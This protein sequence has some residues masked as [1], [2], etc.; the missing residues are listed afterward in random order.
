MSAFTINIPIRI[1][2]ADDVKNA[3][4]QS[5]GYTD[6]IE[7]AGVVVPNP[8]TKEEFVK[9]KC[10]NFMLEITRGYLIEQEEIIASGIAQ[11]AVLTRSQEV[12]GWFD[13]RRLE[14]LGGISVY[15]NFPIVDDLSITTNKNEATNFTLTGTD[16]DSL[17]LNFV[18]TQNPT[19]GTILGTNPNFIYVPSNR[20]YGSD[21]FK[22]KANNGTKK[23]LEGTV[24]ATV[25]RTITAIDAYHP[26][27]KNQS[28]NFTLSSYDTEGTVIYN[29]VDLP[30]HGIINGSNPYEY[31]P[32]T[33]FIGID[34]LSFQ[35]QDDTL[36]S[37][38][39]TITFDITNIIVQPQTYNISMNTNFVFVP[40][41]SNSIGIPSFEITNLPTNGILSQNN[42]EFTFTPNSNFT[43]QD[44][45]EIKAIDFYNESDPALFII[46]VS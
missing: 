6:T 26:I 25:N 11:N 41:T 24:S 5:Y 36:T 20:F 8:I 21:T 33:D 3:F 45:F 40:D 34:T 4:A 37:N 10:I 46:N 42:S 32:D 31:I 17:P 44:S 27:R 18:I 38:T 14:T 39:G 15:Q 23:S 1:I 2:D 13:D 35:V 22:F 12:V 30:Q 16:P 7:I 28:V 43:G 9:Q 29:I 19:H